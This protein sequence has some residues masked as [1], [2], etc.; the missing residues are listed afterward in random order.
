MQRPP[1]PH[2]LLRA[3]VVAVEQCA[4]RI[5]AF[6][7]LRSVAGIVA[8]LD[9]GSGL[10]RFPVG[11]GRPE[12]VLVGA[13][14]RLPRLCR[15]VPLLHRGACPRIKDGDRAVKIDD[16]Q[17]AR[18]AVNS[19]HVPLDDHLNLAGGAVVRSDLHHHA[20]HRLRC[21]CRQPSVGVG[22]LRLVDDQ[23]DVAAHRVQR[24]CRIASR[25]PR[26]RLAGTREVETSTT[27]GRGKPDSRGPDSLR[28]LVVSFAQ[29]AQGLHWLHPI[30]GAARQRQRR[31]FSQRVVLLVVS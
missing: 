9:L 19:D 18:R 8:L 23:L 25:E 24:Q 12:R 10:V 13:D 16:I 3:D 6:L 21:R 29:P 27:T 14:L 15:R 2:W 11:G 7:S 26:Q 17:G 28:D 30:P 5:R 22:W 1:A 4:L 20:P 31:Q